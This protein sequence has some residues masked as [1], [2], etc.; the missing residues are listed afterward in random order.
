MEEHERQIS[1][2][3]ANGDQ[4]Q[5]ARWDCPK[6]ME[7]Q[8]TDEF[9]RTVCW[10]KKWNGRHL[11]QHWGRPRQSW[12]WI[13]HHRRRKPVI[14]NGEEPAANCQGHHKSVWHQAP[15]NISDAAPINVSRHTDGS[16]GCYGQGA[17]GS[18][19]H[20]EEQNSTE[21]AAVARRTAITA[22]FSKNTIAYKVAGQRQWHL[23]SQQAAGWGRT[24]PAELCAGSQATCSP[25]KMRDKNKDPADHV[26]SG[27][28]HFRIRISGETAGVRSVGRRQTDFFCIFN[29]RILEDL[30]LQHK[31]PEAEA[32]PTFSCEIQW[33]TMKALLVLNTYQHRANWLFFLHST[34]FVCL[35]LF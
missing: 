29:H 34:G 32:H 35:S 33:R 4:K 3:S 27:V 28:Q 11:W 17:F 14:W 8:T 26:W 31:A 16:N 21:T 7:I 25:E 19:G 10:I 15:G 13:W 6:S 2:G 1:E 23:A 18:T 24:V 12:Q 20:T 9:Y 5:E 22:F 30:F